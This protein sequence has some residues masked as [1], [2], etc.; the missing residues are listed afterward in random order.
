MLVIFYVIVASG[1]I[2]YRPLV[3][4]LDIYLC[5]LLTIAKNSFWRLLKV[6]TNRV[7]MQYFFLK[8]ELH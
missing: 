3:V 6:H 8:L 1:I 2:Y 7:V 5:E 4:V